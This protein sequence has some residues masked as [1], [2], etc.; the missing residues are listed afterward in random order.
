MK[1][2]VIP[3][4]WRT[5][6]RCA[7][8]CVLAAL[9][10]TAFAADYEAAGPVPASRYIPAGQLQGPEWKVAPQAIND[11]V[12]NNY[13]V[14]SRFGKFPARGS[15]ELGRRAK[16]YAITKA[17]ERALAEKVESW[18][19]LA[20]LVDDMP[21]LAHLAIHW[22]G[23]EPAHLDPRSLLEHLTE[24][25]S[26]LATEVGTRPDLVTDPEGLVIRLTT[27]ERITE[28][29]RELTRPWHDA[30]AAWRGAVAA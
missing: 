10:A 28:T 23:D 5:A 20:E 26:H 13:T 17:G 30:I 29:G 14:E 3:Q 18:R 7:A 24:S 8:G 4:Q 15:T 16:F 21:D 11:G 25:R 6:R 27:R 9:A 12:F 19:R 1:R 22:T 2:D